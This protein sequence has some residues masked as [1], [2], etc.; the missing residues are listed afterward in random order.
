MK[1]SSSTICQ[2]C[3]LPRLKRIGVKSAGDVII[4]IITIWCILSF[5]IIL[6]GIGGGGIRVDDFLILL[7]FIIL[8]FNGWISKI[9]LSTPVKWYLLFIIVNWFSSV[10]NCVSGR[11]TMF[12]S[13]LFVVRMIEYLV[14]YYVGCSMAMIY[15]SFFNPIEI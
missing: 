13:T 1:S 3:Q 8:L 5:K 9:P 14:F 6:V 2:E 7:G 12:T 11:V 4:Y 10:W 15:R